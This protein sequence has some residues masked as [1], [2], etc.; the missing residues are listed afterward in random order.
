MEVGVRLDDGRVQATTALGNDGV[1]II[2]SGEVPVDDWLV[3]QGP[4]PLGRLKLRAIRGQDQNASVM[5]SG[6]AKPL[7]PCQ[8]ALSSTSMT[9]QSHPAPTWFA[10]LASSFSTKGLLSPADRNQTASPEVGCTN[11]VTCSHS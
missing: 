1:E 6:T 3:D 7:G 4:Q 2:R 5:P 8:P 9:W 10:K 11:A